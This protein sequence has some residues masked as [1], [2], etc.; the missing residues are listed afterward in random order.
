MAIGTILL[1]I[2]LVLGIASVFLSFLNLY[3]R[4]DI[5]RRII[6]YLAA[7][8]FL[9]T[10]AVLL[11]LIY[12]FLSSNLDILYVHGHTDPGY[13][14]QYKLAGVWAGE[15]G[16]IILWTWFI[17]LAIAIEELLQIRKARK[18]NDENNRAR[19]YD[20]VRTICLIVLVAFLVLSVQANVFKATNSGEIVW[21]FSGLNGASDAERLD[22]GNILIAEQ[23]NNRVIEV[24]GS[25]NIRRSFDGLDSP[26]DSEGFSFGAD[27]LVLV[28]D[29]DNNSVFEVNGTGSIIW[30][31]TGLDTPVD[32]EWISMGNTLVTEDSRVVEVNRSGGIVWEYAG[33]NQPTDAERLTNGN[34]LITEYGNNRVIEVNSTGDIVWSV[35]GL[36]GPMDAERYVTGITMIT[37]NDRVIDVDGSGNIVWEITGLSGAVDAERLDNGNTLITL[38]NRVIEVESPGPFFLYPNGQGLNP[39][40]LTPLMIFHPPLEFAAFAFITIP[41]AAALGFLITND[42]KWI[43]TS[44]QWSRLSWLTL[45]IA[46]GVGALWAY[47]VLGWGGYWGWDPV[48][49]ANLIPWIA[50]TAFVH[51]QSSYRRKN[52]YIF[53]APLLAIISFVL[54]VFAT[55]ETRSG[56]VTSPLHAFTGP[57][58]DLGA[59]SRLMAILNENPAASFF[60]M[61]MVA[62][63]IAGGILFIWRFAKIREEEGVPEALSGWFPRIYMIFLTILLIYSILNISSFVSI[64]LAVSSVIGIGNQGVGL[65]ILTLLIIG[66]PLMWMVFTSKEEELTDEPL[67]SSRIVN[68]RNT[69]IV[70][71]AIFS[72]WFLT[73]FFLMIMGSGGLQPDVFE[74]RIPLIL[75]PLLLVL[76]ICLLWRHLSA[77]FT[78]YL[79]GV[80]A[81]ALVIFALVY[82]LVLDQVAIVYI[83]VLIAALFASLY[84]TVRVTGGRWKKDSDLWLKVSGTLLLIAGVI[85]IMFWTNLTRIT[86]FSISAK[87]DLTIAILG[88]LAS[89]MALIGGLFSMRRISP[90]L[91]I[92]GAVCAILTLGYFFIGTILGFIALILM[93]ESMSSF[94]KSRTTFRSMRMAV[95][96]ASPHLIHVGAVLLLIGYVASTNLPVGVGEEEGNPFILVENSPEGFEGYQLEFTDSTVEDFDGDGS[97]EIA[98]IHIEITRGGAFV[99][100]ATLRLWWMVPANPFGIPHYMLDLYVENTYFEDLYFIGYAVR[101]NNIWIQAHDQ[102]GLKLTTED[103][104]AVALQVK[105]LPL[106]SALWGGM[107]LL[108]LGISFLVIVGYLPTTRK[109]EEKERPKVEEEVEEIE[110]EEEPPVARKDYEKLLEEE[111]E[112]LED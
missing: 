30:N 12:Y 72:I 109:V 104:D 16:T 83:P 102:S 57:G 103:I 52:Q 38:G 78:I 9:I 73:T 108:M 55:F 62:A 96:T 101:T 95:R 70:A 36:N 40:L 77:R 91:S 2:A 75:V 28:A 67:K 68:D 10:T 43:R 17:F 88:F 71:V 63:L 14:W 11:L 110:K 111:L 92:F 15:E 48:E 59:A 1:Y 3:N 4:K 69:M 58:S 74:S 8:S 98:D 47:V 26:S 105:K 65:A 100:E 79:I 25:D 34:T 54:I 18:S 41:F 51:T 87:P 7:I 81:L 60:F 24:Y 21:E 45:T 49:V 31:V 61:L 50:L 23:G 33:L 99:G 6:R 89:V 112:K 97:Y 106:M 5:Y 82:F 107:W 29:T 66:I 94:S 64:A 46:M 85:G 37:E 19:F 84:K 56:F 86:L 39:L 27:V 80:L 20:W 90:R 93:V 35:D 42:R 53:A 22:N 76:A 13:D 44:L 32:V